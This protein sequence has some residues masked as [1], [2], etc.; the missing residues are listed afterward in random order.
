MLDG[1]TRTCLES[2][3]RNSPS[4]LLGT[5]TRRLLIGIHR[6]LM[7]PLRTEG[8]HVYEKGPRDA[9]C[10]YRHVADTTEGRAA[11]LPTRGDTRVGSDQR[12]RVTAGTHTHRG[13]VLIV[14]RRTCPFSYRMKP[15]YAP[16]SPSPGFLAYGLSPERR[17][18]GAC[19]PSLL[20]N[21]VWPGV[22]TQ[23]SGEL[24]NF[25]P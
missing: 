6:A 8:E 18:V 9:L 21:A 20:P 15:T 17:A 5:S 2:G 1:R 12:S 3:S 23:T 13:R 25:F 24:P 11:C 16:G 14:F 7:N 22:P 10:A 19:L 4:A